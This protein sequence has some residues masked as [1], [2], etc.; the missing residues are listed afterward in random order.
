MNMAPS[1]GAHFKDEAL[2]RLASYGN[3]AQFVSFSPEL[4]QRFSR[5]AGYWA[6]HHFADCASAVRAIVE[7]APEGRVNVRSFRPDCPQGNEFIYGLKDADGAIAEVKRLTSTGLF[8]IVNETID[9]NDG[10]V[11]GVVQGGV[12]EF[13]PGATPRVVDQG[14][15]ASLSKAEG[16]RLLELVYGFQI[17]LDFEAKLR[18][19]FSIHPVRRG[20]SGDHTILWEIEDLPYHVLA[21]TGRWPNAFSEFL[22]DKVFGLLVANAKGCVVP[23]THV[24]CRY[25]VPFVFGE[26]TGSDSRWLRTCPRVPTPGK[27]STV[28][29]WTDPFVLLSTDDPDSSAISSV[30]VQDEVSAQYSG[31]L[32]TSAN[33]EPIIEGVEGFGDSLMLGKARPTAVPEIVKKKLNLLHDSL[34][35]A[36]GSIRLE[37]VY[38]GARVWVVQLQQEAAKSSGAVIVPGDVERE[39]DFKAIEG[40]ER[41]RSLANSLRGSKTGIRLIGNVGITSHMA[42]VLRRAEIPSTLVR[43]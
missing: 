27:F 7:A 39:V 33:G 25:V 5:V 1:V 17:N 42:D 18:V 24:L 8:V 36:F 20:W 30:I 40:L 23:R 9:V 12:V 3:V 35:D 15:P 11:S 4:E 32:L 29:G 19:E 26:P 34:C 22:G 16:V 43:I 38:D 31:G 41:L 28:R 13:A 21:P 14:R 2:D 6:N 37:W 10:G